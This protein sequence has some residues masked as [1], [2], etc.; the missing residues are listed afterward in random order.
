MT[1]REVI[2]YTAYITGCAVSAPLMSTLLSGCAP[3]SVNDPTGY[4]PKFLS[5]KDFKLLQDLVDT[6]LPKTDSPSASDVGVHITIDS[7]VGTIYT[8]EDQ[9]KY[10]KGFLSLSSHLS[11]VSANGEFN[12]LGTEEKLS[13][14]QDLD[15][16]DAEG[17]EARKA[18]LHLK[19]QTISFYLTTEEIGENYLNYLPV[20]GEYQA[21]IPLSDVGNKAWAL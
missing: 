21:C 15:R 4:A 10:K 3:E 19:Q 9:E 5:S 12:A 1:R 11:N 8:T 16:S 6:I 20:P 7:I 2:R 18:Y 17:N 14:L 13:I